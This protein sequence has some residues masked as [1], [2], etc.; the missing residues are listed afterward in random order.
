MPDL[1]GNATNW[2]L[3]QANGLIIIF[4]VVGIVGGV[5]KKSIS[6]VL[7]TVLLGI[8]AIV[9]VNNSDAIQNFA[10]QFATEMMGP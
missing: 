10:T 3:S 8:T 5:F 9:F 4:M 2:I 6:V 7:T 1:V